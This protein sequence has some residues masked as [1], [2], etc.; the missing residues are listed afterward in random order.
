[1][2]RILAIA[3]VLLMVLAGCGGNNNSSTPGDNGGSGSQPEEKGTFTVGMEC[4][5]APFNWTQVESNDTSVS[6]GG[7]GYAD[8]YDVV[9]AKA[10]ADG[11]GKELVIKKIEWTG[12][13]PALSSGEIDAII[14]GMT[15]TPDRKE[16]VDFTEPY[17]ESEMVCIVRAD[18]GL[19][20]ATSL[21]D[22]SGKK[23]LGQLNTLYDDV[24]EQIPDVE[25]LT[26]MQSYPLMVMALQN[27]EADALTGEL[28]VAE[29]VVAANP[30]L[31]IVRFAEG[32]GFEADTTVSIG[33]K[34]GNTDLV[35]E[36]Q[37]ILDTIDGETRL[38]WMRDAVERQPAMEG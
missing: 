27:N 13:E 9:M 15:A 16:G 33:V 26:P 6:L 10:I 18:D 29:G 7:A 36:I 30:D 32:N 20:S 21:A 5:Y 2:K 35:A 22:F 12:L 3:L 28:P 34:K 1:M 17:Y 4:N 23:V 11:L 24:I 37:A 31:A 38:T 14:A 8:G 25:H 19:A